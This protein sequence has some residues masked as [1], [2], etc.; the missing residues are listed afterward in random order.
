MITVACVTA[1]SMQCACSRCKACQNMPGKSPLGIRA[2]CTLLQVGMTCACADGNLGDFCH[3][4]SSGCHLDSSGACCQ[5]ERA[6]AINGECCSG[7][8]SLDSESQCC[9]TGELDACGECGGDGLFVDSLGACCPVPTADANGACCFY[10]VDDCG[11]LPR[12]TTAGA[13]RFLC[14]RAE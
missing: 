11:A 1:Q 7:Y 4:G 6:L 13:E 5:D 3:L 12:L 2:W 10:D 9:A 14:A 8:E